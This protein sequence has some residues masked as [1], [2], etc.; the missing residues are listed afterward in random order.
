M[1]PSPGRG[2]RREALLVHTGECVSGGAKGDEARMQSAIHPSVLL[3]E[4]S[5]LLDLLFQVNELFGRAS[6]PLGVLLRRLALVMRR[7]G[8]VGGR[9][10]LLYIE[11]SRERSSEA[12]PWLRSLDAPRSRVAEQTR[13]RRA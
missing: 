3:Y 11:Q 8:D 12:T 1:A 9:L 4:P 10:S 13:R 5:G 2:H 6:Q 7:L